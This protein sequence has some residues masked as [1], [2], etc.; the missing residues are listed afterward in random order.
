[1]LTKTKEVKMLFILAVIGL[2]IG[3][4]LLTCLRRPDIRQLGFFGIGVI[5]VSL[6]IVIFSFLKIVPAGHVGVV[7]LFGKVSP[8][9]KPAGINIVNPFASLKIMSIKTKELKEIMSVPS[10]EGLSISL[11]ISILHRLDP[12]MAAEVYTKVGGDYGNIILVPQFRSAS[13]GAT[14]NYEAKAL[15]TSGREE[16]SMKIE[17]D[18]APLM[19]QRGVIL[20]KVLLRAVKLPDT[21]SSAIENKLKRE[22]EAEEMKFVLDKEKKESERKIIEAEGIAKAQEIINQTLTASYLQHEAIQAQMKM[23]ESP[24]HTTVYIPV[25]YNGLPLVK[26]VER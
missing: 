8:T 12:S 5:V 4:G 6:V 3:I 7:D 2:L 22:Q 21:V 17:N 1:M 11:D 26:E 16:I 24:N 20:E 23:S 10:K 9:E 25:G 13:R 14:A 19:A 18:L 15:Y